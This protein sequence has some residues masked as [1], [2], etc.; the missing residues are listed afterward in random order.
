MATIDAFV[1]EGGGSSNENGYLAGGL[2]SYNA[3]HKVV[4]ATETLI[5]S[6]KSLGFG[7]TQQASASGPSAGM[8]AGGYSNIGAILSTVRQFAFPTEVLGNNGTS[9]AATRGRLPNNVASAT[10]AYVTFGRQ[11]SG[12]GS[13]VVYKVA[14]DTGT[15]SDIGTVL[16]QTIDLA[17]SAGYSSN[18]KG[19][20][21]GGW[22]NGTGAAG[23]IR[24]ITFATETYTFE[25][26][27]SLATWRVSAAGVMSGTHGYTLGGTTA[28]TT[29]NTSEIDGINFATGVT[30]NPSAALGSAMGNHAATMSTS[31][32]YLFGGSTN[33]S[34]TFTFGTETSASMTA[35]FDAAP[36]GSAGMQHFATTPSTTGDS[37]T[38]DPAP[39][40]SSATA[41]AFAGHASAGGLT[42]VDA[43]AEKAGTYGGYGWQ[44]HGRSFAE[45]WGTATLYKLSFATDTMSE[46]NLTFSGFFKSHTASTSG[47]Y[48]GFVVGGMGLLS[49]S[50][51]SDRVESFVFATETY[52]NQFLFLSHA[53]RN[54]TGVGNKTYGYFGGGSWF[55][56]NAFVYY[57]TIHR[58]AYDG[59]GVSVT[60]AA[61]SHATDSGDC[62]FASATDGY[63]NHYSLVDKL[64][65]ATET[66]SSMSNQF[67]GSYPGRSRCASAFTD[68]AFVLGAAYPE[69]GSK[70]VGKIIFATD[71]VSSLGAILGTNVSLAE[72]ENTSS[73]KGYA[74]D[75]NSTQSIAAD[76]ETCGVLALSL[77][78]RRYYAAGVSKPIDGPI[79]ITSAKTTWFPVYAVGAAD[80][81]VVDAD[82][83]EGTPTSDG[84]NEPSA[85]EVVVD[86]NIAWFRAFLDQMGGVASVVAGGVRAASRQHTADA[87]AD[88]AQGANY[89]LLVDG[90][91]LVIAASEASATFSLKVAATAATSAEE[92]SSAFMTLYVVG[93]APAS[94]DT[95]QSTAITYVVVGD[96]QAI[97]AAIAGNSLATSAIIHEVVAAVA[98]E[99][100]M[101][102]ENFVADIIYVYSPYLHGQQIF[103]MEKC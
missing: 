74:I 39:P 52:V 22:Q 75:D 12:V 86:A 78:Q 19:Y 69:F 20:W 27:A 49:T 80:N 100:A 92:I 15:V 70:D 95:K 54:V 46:P 90:S 2:N 97:A 65:F 101:L 93:T 30:N 56:G 32:G 31:K 68:K 82:G 14:I 47:E 25:S 51:Y 48:T 23:N 72:T 55:D 38:G 21:S 64:S 34:Q 24:S 61:L 9:L 103:A 13:A 6:H 77:P 45:D 44:L 89:K 40:G 41:E 5:D 16:G 7:I 87:V 35:T 58:A 73:V 66:R 11:S 43:Q 10:H 59:S 71:T 4:F 60:A 37:S 8:M 98:G 96:G 67:P 17:A 28:L 79:D 83:S 1:N 36:Y 29:G 88:S 50:T 57:D 42:L 3:L 81:V 84:V 62:G 63:F 102:G 94:G 85:A 33:I 76:T 99:F 53:M 91:A 26:A 18:T